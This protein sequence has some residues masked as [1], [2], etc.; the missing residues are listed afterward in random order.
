MAVWVLNYRRSLACGKGKE[1]NEGEYLVLINKSGI[2]SVVH[3][4]G[5]GIDVFSYGGFFVLASA[6]G[7]VSAGNPYLADSLIAPIAIGA[8]VHYKPKFDKVKLNQGQVFRSFQIFNHKFK[9][10]LVLKSVKKIMF[11]MIQTFCNHLTS[12]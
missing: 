3:R 11:N 2:V 5:A 6:K 10:D 9:I 4:S 12:E 1:Y 7:V 8:L